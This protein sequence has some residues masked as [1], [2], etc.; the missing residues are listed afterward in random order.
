[1][2]AHLVVEVVVIKHFGVVVLEM[3][4]RFILQIRRLT[5]LESVQDEAGGMCGLTPKDCQLGQM[6]S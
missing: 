2:P 6:P 3:R 1:M 5:T 4:V